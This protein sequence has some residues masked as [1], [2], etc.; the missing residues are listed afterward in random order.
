M[1]NMT[2]RKKRSPINL[3][4]ESASARVSIMHSESLEELIDAS[5]FY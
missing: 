3:A 1:I 2:N 4:S 5:F